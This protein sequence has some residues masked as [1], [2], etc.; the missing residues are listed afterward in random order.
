MLERMIM[1][2]TVPVP[3]FRRLRGY[4]SDP[5]LSL[6]LSTMLVNDLIYQ[7]P[8]EDLT[9]RTDE[10]GT[11]WPR[12]EYLEIVDYDPASERF[13]FFRRIC[14]SR[15]AREASGSPVGHDGVV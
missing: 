15:R 13:W 10:T 11:S 8:W 9:P 3:A 12:G 4:A 7:V 5:S 14:G 2:P 1:R 6:S